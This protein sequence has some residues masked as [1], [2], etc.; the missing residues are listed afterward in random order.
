MYVNICKYQ[1]LNITY[2]HTH[3]HTYIYIPSNGLNMERIFEERCEELAVLFA[4]IPVGQGDTPPALNSCI[5]LKRW[6]V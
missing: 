4:E 1:F 2:I 5:F 3:T 6:P